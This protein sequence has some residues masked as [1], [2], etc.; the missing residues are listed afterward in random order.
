MH[1]MPREEFPNHFVGRD[2]AGRF[3][4]RGVDAEQRPT[5][6]GVAASFDFDEDDFAAICPRTKCMA[7]HFRAIV[8]FVGQQFNRRLLRAAVELRPNAHRVV[9]RLAVQ[10]IA[11]RCGCRRIEPT[12][13]RS[14][15]NA[16]RAQAA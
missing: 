10:Q 4:Q 14:H 15:G 11:R 8:D 7:C 9:D 12:C 16:A 6:P 2:V 1:R 5:G 3:S 13:L